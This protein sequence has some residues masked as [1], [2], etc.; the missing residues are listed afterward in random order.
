VSKPSAGRPAL[1]SLPVEAL[2][3][4]DET[5][6]WT[7]RQPC[8]KEDGLEYAAVVAGCTDPRQESGPL[9]PKATGS[10]TPE[11]AAASEADRTNMSLG[12]VSRPLSGMPAGTTPDAPM[13]TITGIP[14]GEIQKKTPTM[15]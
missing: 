7:S 12:D 11:P 13:D 9:K 4:A 2:S 3:A 14:A 15:F 6:T 5:V 1:S 8:P 10:G